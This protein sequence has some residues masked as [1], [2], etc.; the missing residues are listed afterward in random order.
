MQFVSAYVNN[1]ARVDTT[2]TAC[3][4]LTRLQPLRPLL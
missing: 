2:P 3:G 4:E 1:I